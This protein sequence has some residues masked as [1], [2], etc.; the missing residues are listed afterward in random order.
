MAEPTDAAMIAEIRAD[1]E[2]RWSTIGCRTRRDG[3]TLRLLAIVERQWEQLAEAERL[4]QT[5][6]RT[7]LEVC[8]ENTV[9]RQQRDVA[10]AK[11]DDLAA[12]LAEAEGLARQLAAV[13][14]GYQARTTTDVAAATGLV[15]A[16]VEEET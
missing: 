10:E 13:H 14:A 2:S 3:Y 15:A 9:L 16:S 4:F 8:S 1:S 12:R 11:R 7:K 6:L 5:S